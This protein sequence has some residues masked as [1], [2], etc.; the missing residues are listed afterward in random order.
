VPDG[1]ADLSVLELILSQA[2]SQPTATK[3]IR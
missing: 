3:K 1:H 2:R